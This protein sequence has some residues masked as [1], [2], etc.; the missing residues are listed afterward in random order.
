MRQPFVTYR[1]RGGF[2]GSWERTHQRTQE[3]GGRF[4]VQYSNPHRTL[5]KY[6]NCYQLSR[7]CM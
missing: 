5:H 3:G 2:K 1:E 6:D 4:I 7:G